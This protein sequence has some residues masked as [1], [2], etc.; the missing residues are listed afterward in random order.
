MGGPSVITLENHY[1]ITVTLSS[2]APR[3]T[4]RRACTI[5]AMTKVYGRETS[6]GAIRYVAPAI[7]GPPPLPLMN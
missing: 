5:R 4:H 3:T 7:F 1:A 6:S 2:R